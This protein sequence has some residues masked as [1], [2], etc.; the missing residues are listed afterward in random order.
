MA[1]PQDVSRVSLA[2]HFICDGRHRSSFH[3]EPASLRAGWDASRGA[4]GFTTTDRTT[5]ARSELQPERSLVL[6]RKNPVLPRLVTERNPSSRG[7]ADTPHGAGIP[8]MG[9]LTDTP[10]DPV[11]RC[12][13]KPGHNG[14]PFFTLRQ[15]VCVRACPPARATPS[16]ALFFLAHL[17]S[18][19]GSGAEHSPG[20]SS[21]DLVSFLLQRRVPHVTVHLDVPSSSPAEGSAQQRAEK[22]DWTRRSQS[23]PKPSGGGGPGLMTASPRHREAAPAE[24]VGPANKQQSEGLAIN[25]PSCSKSYSHCG[26]T[27]LPGAGKKKSA[28][29]TLHM[30][31]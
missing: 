16:A 27:R 8:Y 18:T 28:A 22:T 5:H 13:N 6:L 11:C 19:R 10:G 12:N 17:F 15:P 30:H 26:Q 23:E 24:K 14:C 2:N 7:T 29:C 9:P 25:S 1:R 20:E 31:M 3:L 4:H 21:Q